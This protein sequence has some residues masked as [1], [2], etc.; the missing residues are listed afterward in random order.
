MDDAVEGDLS[1][2][3]RSARFGTSLQLDVEHRLRSLVCWGCDVLVDASVNLMGLDLSSAQTLIGPLELDEDLLPILQI[4][5]SLA[6]PSLSIV[7]EPE[8]VGQ[9]SLV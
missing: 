5:D 3:H 9:V 6:Y 8:R 1:F 2:S 4:W 7:L